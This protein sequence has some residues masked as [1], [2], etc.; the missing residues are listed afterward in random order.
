MPISRRNEAALIIARL[1]ESFSVRAVLIAISVVSFLLTFRPFSL[2]LESNFHL[3]VY[4]GL[5]A[6][7]VAVLHINHFLLS[8]LM[9][10]ITFVGEKYRQSLSACILSSCTILIIYL[11]LS[12]FSA[13]ESRL[14][15][16][17]LIQIILVGFLPAIA[18]RFLSQRRALK[19]QVL[20]LE[21]ESAK[22]LPNDLV[23]MKSVNGKD[24]LQLNKNDILYIRA[25][26]NYVV[27]YFLDSQD[28]K[29]LLLRTTLSSLEN[30][31][32]D[33]GIIRCHRSYL[34]NL[35]NVHRLHAH[36]GGHG[37]NIR[38]STF[39]VPVSRTYL[40]L[41]RQSIEKLTVV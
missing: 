37:L 38:G 35:A 30:L 33:I 18:T 32:S 22:L 28:L 23:Q 7:I 39:K 17:L 34:V 24:T 25:E 14:S 11:Y 41:V 3:Y 29:E 20:K 9:Q 10:R 19:S 26:D 6:V 13:E 8:Q 27:I 5:G 1:T 16:T 2:S 15:I 36:S 12:Y 31:L 40:P 21:A 4:L